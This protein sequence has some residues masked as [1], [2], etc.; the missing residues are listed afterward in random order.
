MRSD[1]GNVDIGSIAA[2]VSGGNTKQ[3]AL[4][5]VNTYRLEET[6]EGDLR[7][8][9]FLKPEVRDSDLL[10][11][12]RSIQLIMFVSPGAHSGGRC[13]LVSSHE[14]NRRIG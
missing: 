6:S 2:L 7:C 11:Y 9:V 3:L 13:R 1:G 4:S 5:K 12:T 14:G 8:Q 10:V